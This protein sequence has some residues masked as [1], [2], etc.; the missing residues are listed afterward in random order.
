[1]FKCEFCGREFRKT[2]NLG[3]H[4]FW[5]DPNNKERQDKQRIIMAEN[6]KKREITKETREKLR[7]A[8]I[9]KILSKEHKKKI[10]KANTGKH[11][12]LEIRKRMSEVHKGK[13]LSE[14]TRRKISESNKGRHPSE[15]TKRRIGEANSISLKGKKLSEE[16]KRKISKANKG[17]R[18]SQ[19]AIEAHKGK[20]PTEETKKKI[21]LSVSG[22]RNYNWKGGISKERDIFMHRREWKKAWRITYQRYNGMC[23]H[24]GNPTILSINQYDEHFPNVHHIIGYECKSLRLVLSNLIL[25][26]HGCHLWVHSKANKRKEFVLEPTK[27]NIAKMIKTKKTGTLLEYIYVYNG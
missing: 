6:I 1:M 11:P 15:E 17:R 23:Q 25:L 5:C 8:N 3:V 9:G 14:E 12:S 4:K 2:S 21:A 27:E 26:C 16:T 19:Q 10:A 20:H 18:L 22:P 7:Q 13:R 24:C